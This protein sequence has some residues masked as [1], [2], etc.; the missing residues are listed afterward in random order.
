MRCLICAPRCDHWR[1]LR[2]RAECGARCPVETLLASPQAGGRPFWLLAAGTSV[3][4]LSPPWAVSQWEGR[5]S[6]SGNGYECPLRAA[7]SRVLFS[8]DAQC[9]QDARVETLTPALTPP[10][11]RPLAILA[12]GFYL[13]GARP[14]PAPPALGTAWHH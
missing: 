2:M 11:A 7:P 13:G 6:H 4:P 10:S 1:C 5:G 3:L 9:T 8:W 14:L 12:F